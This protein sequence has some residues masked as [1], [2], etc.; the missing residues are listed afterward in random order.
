M[1]NVAPH[2][3]NCMSLQPRSTGTLQYPGAA[4]ERD[5]L[6]ATRAGKSVS[7]IR[8]R[9]PCAGMQHAGD[10]NTAWFISKQ[11][12]KTALAQL[13]FVI[14]PIVA[15]YKVRSDLRRSLSS[16]LALSSPLPLPQ[17]LITKKKKNLIHVF[18]PSRHAQFLHKSLSNLHVGIPSQLLHLLWPLL[19]P[20]HL[21]L[22]QLLMGNLPAL[23]PLRLLL[24]SSLPN[25]SLR[26][27]LP[28]P[29]RWHAGGLGRLPTRDMVP[30]SSSLQSTLPSRA[31]S[32]RRRNRRPHRCVRP[33]AGH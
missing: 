3:Q 12:K 23:R 17:Q 9:R 25:W 10:L 22:Q 20:G 26:A 21:P 18:R 27:G 32:H 30:R 4:A 15:P 29:R 13:H 33:Q 16:F 5:A 11:K 8:V 31:T 1:S 28:L 24:P 7:A 19:P 6:V 14:H 2:F